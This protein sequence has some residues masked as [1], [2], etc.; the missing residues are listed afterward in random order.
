MIWVVLND[1]AANRGSLDAAATAIVSALVRP[2]LNLKVTRIDHIVREDFH[3][4][5]P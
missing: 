3:D 1:Y 2:V 4:K 5:Y